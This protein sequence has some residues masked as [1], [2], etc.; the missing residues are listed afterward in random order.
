MLRESTGREGEQLRGSTGTRGLNPVTMV[1]VSLFQF[2]HACCIF[3]HQSLR[4]GSLLIA[5]LAHTLA[6]RE[7]SL[8]HGKEAESLFGLPRDMGPPFSHAEES[9]AQPPS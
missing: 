6:T 7:F 2:L 4:E 5:G 8:L 3:S 9:S 1:S